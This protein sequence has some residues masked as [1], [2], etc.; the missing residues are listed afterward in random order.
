MSIQIV[1]STEAFYYKDP[2]DYKSG[3]MVDWTRPE[4]H[5]AEC[6]VKVSTKD[7]SLLE[8]IT[9]NSLEALMVE[10]NLFSG[11]DVACN[12]KKDR[13]WAGIVC[14]KV[15]VNTVFMNGYPSDRPYGDDAYNFSS[16]V[17]EDVM[18]YLASSFPELDE[19]NSFNTGLSTIKTS[20]LAK[21]ILGEQLYDIRQVKNSSGKSIV[22]IGD[23]VAYAYGDV[24]KNDKVK[25]ISKVGDAIQLEFENGDILPD[26]AKSGGVVRMWF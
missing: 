16:K 7:T 11:Q 8:R 24:L 4:L 6:Y 26:Y 13:P 21:I 25:K 10:S 20:S 12:V 9:K 22:D 23:A 14:F 19:K 3:K 1:K 17:A 18:H 5:C 2:N 15:Y